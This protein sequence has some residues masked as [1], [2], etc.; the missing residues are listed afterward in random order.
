MTRRSTLCGQAHR[1]GAGLL[2][3]HRQRWLLYRNA[4]TIEDP[5]GVGADVSLSA[6]DDGG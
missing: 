1:H 6:A 3:A 5:N 2:L 4:G